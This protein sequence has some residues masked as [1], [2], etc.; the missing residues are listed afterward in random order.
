MNYAYQAPA[1]LFGL[2]CWYVIYFFAIKPFIPDRSWEKEWKTLD[3]YWEKY[4]D[5][6]TEHGPKCHN[7]GSNNIRQFGYQRSDDP[8][9]IHKCNQCNTGLYRT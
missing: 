2:L 5:C 9:R 1:F 6:K 4:P 3:E 7:C 8:R